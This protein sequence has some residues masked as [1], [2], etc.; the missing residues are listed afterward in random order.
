MNQ[1]Y[2]PQNKISKKKTKIFMFL[3]VFL[4]LIIIFVF[5]YNLNKKVSSMINNQ[6]LIMQESGNL[7]ESVNNFQ[8]ILTIMNQDINEPRAILGLKQNDYSIFFDSD[9]TIKDSED[10]N[11]NILFFR[12]LDYLNDLEKSEKLEQY[13]LEISNNEILD[14]FIREND[15]ILEK[16]DNIIYIKKSN[17]EI[18]HIEY[19][20]ENDEI[21]ITSMMGEIKN[22]NE[23]DEKEIEDLNKDL[24]YILENTEKIKNEFLELFQ[25]EHILE[26]LENKSLS[27]SDELIYIEYGYKAEIK[28]EDNIL[29][30]IFYDIK[31]NEYVLNEERFEDRNE[32][33]DVLISNLEELDTKTPIEKIVELSQKEIVDILHDQ[34]FLDVLQKYNLKIND[35]ARELDNRLYYD[36]FDENDLTIASFAIDKSTGEILLTDNKGVLIKKL[37][38]FFQNED[39]KKKN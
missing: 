22:I 39:N 36:I 5:N 1:I 6:N 30:S 27:F 31:S 2:T 7:K 20:L 37:S 24:D 4:V 29:L 9:D 17:D 35:F 26:I 25:N 14:E 12:A 3:F 28:L 19:D 32:F 33:L 10:I 11:K 8:Q 34:A 16:Q 23:F 21:I 18:F 15:L 13:I 38:D